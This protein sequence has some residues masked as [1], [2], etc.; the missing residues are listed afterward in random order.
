MTLETTKI[1]KNPDNDEDD[2]HVNPD[3]VDNRNKYGSTDYTNGDDS[4]NHNYS[5]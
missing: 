1:T 2:N 5:T 4:V 3:K